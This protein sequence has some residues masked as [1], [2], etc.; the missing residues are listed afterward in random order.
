V[1]PTKASQQH[2]ST[3]TRQNRSSLRRNFFGRERVR[4]EI[5][6][7]WHVLA[8]EEEWTQSHPWNGRRYQIA[9]IRR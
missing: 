7:R 4:I 3:G 6:G 8:I 2:H 1:L 9:G 5:G